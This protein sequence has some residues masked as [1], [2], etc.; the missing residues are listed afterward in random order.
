MKNIY[1]RPLIETDIT[2]TYLEYFK[3]DDV[4]LFL[5]VTN[6]ELTRESVIAYIKNGVETKDYYMYAICLIENDQHIG[7]LKIGPIDRKQKIS[8]LVTVIWNKSYW[9][10]GLASEAIKLGN[11]LAFEK[12]NIR[13]LHGGMY[14]DNIGSIKAYTK[15]GW[16][17]EATLQNHYILNGKLQD[18]VIV[19]CFNPSYFDA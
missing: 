18:R 9:G 4:L 15:A 7:N 3:D 8:D 19:S 11:K 12:H 1:L 17:I 16:I 10:K 5:E 6:S 13:K 14:S 2:E